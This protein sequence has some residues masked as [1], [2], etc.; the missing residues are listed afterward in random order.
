MKSFLVWFQLMV[1]ATLPC[2]AVA[3]DV[4]DAQVGFPPKSTMEAALIRGENVYK[5]YCVL[6]H[7]VEADGQGRA[8]KQ[9]DPKPANLMR[10]PYPSVYK[11]MIIRRGGEALGRSKFMPPW[12]QELTDEQISDLVQYLGTLVKPQ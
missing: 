11:E 1:L 12:E 10:S 4:Q 2:L 3:K 8:A 6:C 5:R 9:Y 7:G